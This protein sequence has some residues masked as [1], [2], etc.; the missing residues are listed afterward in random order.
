MFNLQI[1]GVPFYQR[2]MVF[3]YIWIRGYFVL[4]FASSCSPF[5]I[6]S[7]SSGWAVFNNSILFRILPSGPGWN[8]M[9]LW[10]LQTFPL[11]NPSIQ[12]G[13]WCMALWQTK[14]RNCLISRGKKASIRMV[15][16][17]PGLCCQNPEKRDGRGERGFSSGLESCLLASCLTESE[18]GSSWLLTCNLEQI[19][20]WLGLFSWGR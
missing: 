8:D 6:Y 19:F 20:G 4:Q 14:K 1:K 15:W 2:K 9:L 13:N 16:H 5:R 17:M 11:H 3:L 12:W 7:L 10:N 18:V